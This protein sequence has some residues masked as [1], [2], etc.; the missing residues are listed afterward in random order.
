MI[1]SAEVRSSSRSE[2]MV[3][4]GRFSIEDAGDELIAFFAPG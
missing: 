3:I 2:R 4:S 1:W